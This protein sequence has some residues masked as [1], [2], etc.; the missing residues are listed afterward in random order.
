[1]NR[2][3]VIEEFIKNLE[4]K[5]EEAKRVLKSIEKQRRDA[6][7][8]MESASDTTRFQKEKEGDVCLE[9]IIILKNTINYLAGLKGQKSGDK[10]QAGS[11]C[12]VKDKTTGEIKSY[13]FVEKTGGI[14]LDKFNMF[15][16]SLDA[17]VANVFLGKKVGDIVV[18]K[19]EME[20][21]EIF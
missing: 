19:N 8:F 14:V 17:P 9:Q 2:E 6:P 11:I 16:V 5:I 21:I 4:I 10:I 3:E 12:T 20:I 18:F 15:L 7:G 1:M 13:F